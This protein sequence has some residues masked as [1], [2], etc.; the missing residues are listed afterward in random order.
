MPP[1]P[2]APRAAAAAAKAGTPK[3][4]AAKKDTAKKADAKAAP[5]DKGAAAEGGSGLTTEEQ[6]RVLRNSIDHES[7]IRDQIA[8]LTG[9]VR[10][11]DGLATPRR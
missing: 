1:K 9:K 3:A 2:A 7:K 11:F 5:A 8:A 6:D 4:G 10:L